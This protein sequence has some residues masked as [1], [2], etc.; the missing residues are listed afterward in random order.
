MLFARLQGEY[1]GP[2]PV[3]VEGFSDDT[4]RHLAHQFLCTAHIAYRWAAKGHGYAE[5]LPVA[6]CYV[7]SPFAGSLEQSQV[8]GYAVHYQQ[9]LVGMTAVSQSAEVLD[10][11]IAV[12]LLNHHAGC[13]S[14]VEQGVEG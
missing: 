9:R 5:R 4:A 7:G 13:G 1:E 6:D 3:A 11:T 8:C 12:G 2:L 14:L 10:D